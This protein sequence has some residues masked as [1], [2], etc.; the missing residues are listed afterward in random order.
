MSRSLPL[1]SRPNV[2]VAR[3]HARGLA[4]RLFREVLV[5]THVWPRR[6]P[7]AGRSIRPPVPD[8]DPTPVAKSAT[9]IAPSLVLRGHR[10][11]VGK[12]HPDA[13]SLSEGRG[14]YVCFASLGLLALLAASPVRA[15]APVTLSY[16]EARA[17]NAQRVLWPGATA[18]DP[19][20]APAPVVGLLLWL[21]R[22]TPYIYVVF[23][24]EHTG[25]HYVWPGVWPLTAG[26][27]HLVGN[28]ADLP[29]VDVSY[30]SDGED[31]PRCRAAYAES[32]ALFGFPVPARFP[33]HHADF[34]R[35]VGAIL[36]ALALLGAVSW[37]LHFHAGRNDRKE[38]V[39]RAYVE[40][41]EAGVRQREQYA[42]HLEKQIRKRLGD[43]YVDPTTLGP[44]GRL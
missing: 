4:L 30:G 26:H 1:P 28:S 29:S 12:K 17:S 41:L 44:A 10:I 2:Y 43:T 15:A 11:E 24:R 23:P 22:E 37:L 34:A 33:V 14:V 13:A 25:P 40:S 19:T 5:L 32:E 18:V 36:A 20:L 21:D 38:N 42:D 35:G 31:A 16:A 8:F 6:A 3:C 39:R 9:A 27:Y 7:P